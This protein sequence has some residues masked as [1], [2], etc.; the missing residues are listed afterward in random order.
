MEKNA[1]IYIAGH[2]GMVGSAI[3]RKLTAEGYTNII[4]RLSSELDLRNQ[5]QVADF[6]A[7]EKPD[8]VF[9]AAAKVGGI[10]ANNTYRAEFLY[11][12]LQIQ[13]NII[14][15]SYLNGVKK[16]MFLGSSC[17]YPKMAPQPLKEEYLLTG[18]LEPTNEPYAIAKIA[19]IKMCDAYRAQYSCNYISVMPTNLYGYNDNYHPQNSHVLPALIRRFHEAKVANA[20]DV[21]IWGTGSPMREFLFADDLAEACY[22]LMQNYDEEGLVNIGTGEDLTIKDLATLISKVVGYEGEIKFDTSKPDGTP[23]KLMDVSK[24]HSQGWK[25]KIELEEGI[26][27]AYQDFLSRY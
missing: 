1:K 5:Q 23:R 15:S 11:D 4:T 18:T 8:Y 12:N 26:A 27:L 2:R 17:I 25:H 10:V 24:L 20:P 16:L 13:N 21:T 3:H 7:A 22:Y 9:L 6:F 14:H 19:G